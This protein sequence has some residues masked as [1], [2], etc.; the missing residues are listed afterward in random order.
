MVYTTHKN[1]YWFTFEI[2]TLYGL[3]MYIKKKKCGILR[4]QKTIVNRKIEYIK[5]IVV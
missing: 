3:L 5:Y 2:S 1:A 4:M